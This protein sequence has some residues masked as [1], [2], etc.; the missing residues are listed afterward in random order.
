MSHS[1]TSCTALSRM[2]RLVLL[3]RCL[4][5]GG[6]VL[7]IHGPHKTADGIAMFR[8]LD[9]GRDPQR[10]F[11]CLLMAATFI[12]TGGTRWSLGDRCGKA[13]S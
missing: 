10:T 5:F 13:Y 9:A 7:T 11:L 6:M 3:L 1:R 4:V 12:G 2:Q 8:N